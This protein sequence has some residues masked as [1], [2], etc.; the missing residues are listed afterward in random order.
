MIEG[1]TLDRVVGEV[2]SEKTFEQG[3]GRRDKPLQ[4]E[5]HM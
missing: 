4:R 1:I 3:H 2:L 5:S